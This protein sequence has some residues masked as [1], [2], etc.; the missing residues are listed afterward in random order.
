[1]NTLQARA[2]LETWASWYLP[3]PVPWLR[4]T[5]GHN[6]PPELQNDWVDL[7]ASHTPGAHA[8]ATRALETMADKPPNLLTMRKILREAETRVLPDDHGLEPQL[9]PCPKCRGLRYVLTEEETTL[10]VYTFAEPC[11]RCQGSGR[12]PIKFALNEPAVSLQDWHAAQ[13]AQDF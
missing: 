6:Q 7:I 10:G 12:V 2:L 13:A 3:R 9:G 4:Y 5:N 8:Q 11:N 1:M